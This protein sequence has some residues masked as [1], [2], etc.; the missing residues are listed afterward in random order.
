M[1]LKGFNITKQGASHIK[2]NKECQDS[3]R[4]YH[5]EYCTLAIVA[6]GHGGDDYVRSAIGSKFACEVMEEKFIEFFRIFSKKVDIMPTDMQIRDLKASII[7]GWKDKINDYHKNNSFTNEEL[8]R[9]SSKA[10]KRYIE[11]GEIEAAY[12]TTLIGV[13]IGNGYW[14]GLHIGDGKFVEVTNK[15]EFKQPV[16]W[17]DKCFLNSTTSIC[18]SNALDRFRDFSSNE[19]PAAFLLCSDGID[20]SFKGEEQLYSFYKTILYSFATSDVDEAIKGLDEYLPRLSSQ[21]SGDDI[22]IAAIL[23]LEKIKG[24]NIIKE[25]DPEK[26][27]ARKEENAKKLIAKEKEEQERK[28]REAEQKR[29]QQV[30]LKEIENKKFNSQE[31]LLEEEE[32]HI[33][34]TS[35]DK[36]LADNCAHYGEA[37]VK[38]NISGEQKTIQQVQFPASYNGHYNKSN[39]NEECQVN[40]RRKKDINPYYE[41]IREEKIYISGEIY[42]KYEK[43]TTIYTSYEPGKSY[44]QE[45]EGK[46]D[47]FFNKDK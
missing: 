30:A 1:E 36:V 19:I 23:D 39:Q 42:S 11:N 40:K 5:N 37:S 29:Q 38:Q 26:E 43:T 16:P 31:L 21:G 32:N 4:Y 20:D 10:Y 47:E 35:Q 41:R 45:Y 46:I 9:I 12:G 2:K 17:D 25:Y 7:S 18:D 28:E 27:R 15:G 22:S 14:I 33:N 24:L 3:S 13:G 6:D 34:R 8:Q 44:L